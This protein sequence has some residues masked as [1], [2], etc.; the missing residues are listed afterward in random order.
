MH[1]IPIPRQILKTIHHTALVS[2]DTPH[3]HPF[4]PPLTVGSDS[5]VST[6]GSTAPPTPTTL[7]PTSAALRQHQ[8]GFPDKQR[9]HTSIDC[10]LEATGGGGWPNC[11]SK[12]R[13]SFG[14]HY[15]GFRRVS[16]LDEASHLQKQYL[17]KQTSRQHTHTTPMKHE[18]TLIVTNDPSHCLMG[19]QAT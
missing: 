13:S 6:P 15:Q 9:Q 10:V 14:H 7:N 5:R 17:L 19:H 12:I 1:A 8:L 18:T 4:T 2:T 3:K 11:H 16:V